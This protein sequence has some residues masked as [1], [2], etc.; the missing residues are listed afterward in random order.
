MY[1]VINEFGFDGSQFFHHLHVLD[2]TKEG[3]WIS[4]AVPLSRAQQDALSK[5]STASKIHAVA[6]GAPLNNNDHL[7]SSEQILRTE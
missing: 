4:V 7:I 3:N 2:L 6:A 1:Q 5:A